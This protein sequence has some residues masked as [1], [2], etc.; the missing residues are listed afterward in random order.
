MKL[1]MGSKDRVA[2]AAAL[3]PLLVLGGILI[4]PGGWVALVLYVLAGVMLATGVTGSCPI[5]GVAGL[6]TRDRTS[7]R[8]GA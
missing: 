1:N 2:R 8:P 4:G 6:S 7:T 5:Y 3:A